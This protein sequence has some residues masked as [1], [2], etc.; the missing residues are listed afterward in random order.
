MTDVP[1]SHKKKTQLAKAKEEYSKLEK[2]PLES[3]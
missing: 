2:I 3:K 1:V